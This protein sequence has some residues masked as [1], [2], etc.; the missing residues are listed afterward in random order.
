MELRDWADVINA[1]F[2]DPEI[3]PS[4]REKTI[5]YA[6]G[7]IVDNVRVAQ[8]RFYTG[9]EYEAWRARILSTPLP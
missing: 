5:K 3:T 2:P 8:G 1:D 9:K 6:Q 7:H 4:S